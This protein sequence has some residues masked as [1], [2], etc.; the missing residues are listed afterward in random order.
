[1]PVFVRSSEQGFITRGYPVG[2][3]VPSPGEPKKRTFYLFNHVRIIVR[4]HDDPTGEEYAGSRI[5]GFEVLPMSIKHAYDETVP[6]DSKTVKLHTCGGAAAPVGS[7]N[8]Q[9]VE[10]DGEEVVA[11]PP[12]EDDHDFNFECT[13]LPYHPHP[14][15][16][17]LR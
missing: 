10:A 1:M 13:P 12:S 6:F 7:S 8:F 3:H 5:V 2:F 16:L 4:H 17:T 15:T 9:P 14:I 11:P